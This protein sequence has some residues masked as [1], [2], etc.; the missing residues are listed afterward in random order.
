MCP[1]TGAVATLPVVPGQ[2]AGLNHSVGSPA[3][4]VHSKVGDGAGCDSVDW[5]G[6]WQWHDG[7]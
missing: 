1:A 7:Q 6:R 5:C 2:G 3:D 4:L